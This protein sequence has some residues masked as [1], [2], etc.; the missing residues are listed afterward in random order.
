[1]EAARESKKQIS[2][3][4]KA[5]GLP[6]DALIFKVIGAYHAVKDDLLVRGWIEND[7]EPKGEK[8]KFTS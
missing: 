8:D 1:M 3:Y 6:T 7:W 5:H 2:A 4:K